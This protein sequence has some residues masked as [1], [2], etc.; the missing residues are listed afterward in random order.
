MIMRKIYVV[1]YLLLVVFGAKAQNPFLLTGPTDGI[2]QYGYLEKDAT[3]FMAINSNSFGNIF[4]MFGRTFLNGNN[5]LT[6]GTA[7]N[8]CAGAGVIQT[9]NNYNFGA[10]AIAG[11]I[12]Y[13]SV[14]A[15][16]CGGSNSYGGNPNTTGFNERQHYIFDVTDRPSDLATNVV[17]LNSATLQSTA[18][19]VMSLKIDFDA[20]STRTLE[21]LFIQN[22][23]TMLE[24]TD[25]ANDG[26]RVYYEAAT[27]TEVFNGT[28][29]FGTLFGDYNLNPTNNNIYGNDAINIPI[30]AGGL[31]IYVVLN[32]F[33]SCSNTAKTVQ[34]ST[35]NDG[36]SFSPAMDVSYRLARVN[37]Q[38]AAP[39]TINVSPVVNASPFSGNYYIPS[40]CYPTLASFITALNAGTVGGSITVNVAAGYTETATAGGFNITQTGTVA[41]PIV[42][43]K[44][45]AGANPTFTASGAHTAGSIVDAVF[46]IVGADYITI[47]GFTI[48]ENA[49]NVTSTP[50]GSNNMTEFGVGLFYTTVTDGPQNNTIRNCTISLNSTYTNTFGI[51]SNTQ[52]SSTSGTVSANITNAAT[53][54]SNNNRVYGCAISNVNLGIVFVGTPALQNTGIDIGG[55]SAATGNTLTNIGNSATATTYLGT[56]GGSCAGI[57]VSLSDGSNISYNS[58]TTAAIAVN[59]YG[60]YLRSTGTASAATH[61]SNILNNTITVS[62]SS[63]NATYSLAGILNDLG[64]ANHTLNMNNN[65]IQNSSTSSATF[66][67]A[68]AAIWSNASANTINITGN[69]IS[70]NTITGAALGTTAATRSGLIKVQNAPTVSVNVSNNTCLN[71]AFNN[72]GTGDIVA[73]DVSGSYVG[74]CTINNNSVNVLSTTGTGSI[75]GYFNGASPTGALTCD[76]NTFS[77]VTVSG[78]GSTSAIRFFSSST[79]AG[80]SLIIRNNT[81]YKLNLNSAVASLGV[82]AINTSISNAVTINNNSIRNVVSG[83][84][85]YGIRTSGGS[86]THSVYNNTVD[87]L[88]SPGGSGINHFG[89]DISPSSTGISN[90]YNNKVYN[91]SSMTSASA[92]IYGI[93][94]GDG[95]TTNIYN[96]MVADLKL[97]AT[98]ISASSALRG[99]TVRAVGTTANIYNN[100]VY[101]EGTSSGTD[102]SSAAFS[103]NGTT[104]NVDIRNN[105]FVNNCTPK[106]TGFAAAIMRLATGTNG[107]VPTNYASTSNNNCLFAPSVANGVVYV[108]GQYTGGGP[109][110]IYQ[111]NC[112]DINAFKAFVSTRESA[113]F[114]EIPPFASIAAGSSDL[115]IVPA[116]TSGCINGGQTIALTAADIDGA[117][118]PI[119]AAYEIGADEVAGTTADKTP[120]TIT[121]T[122]LGDVGCTT[123]APSLSATITDANTL[124][125]GTTAPRLY[126]KKLSDATNTIATAN[127]NSVGGW[128]YV[129]TASGASPYSFTFDYSLLPG[130]LISGDVIQYFVAAQDVSGN[131]ATTNATVKACATTVAFTS[132]QTVSSPPTI[133]Q[134]TYRGSIS[135]AVTIGTGLGQTYPTLSGVGGLFEAINNGYVSGDITATVTSNT[136]ETGAVA[137]NEWAEYNTGTCALTGTAVYRLT[138]QSD[139][140][141]RNLVGTDLVYNATTLQAMIN[142]NGADRVTFTGGT[143]TQR[144]LV[145][146]STHAT[147]T[148][149]IPVFQMGNVNG[150][151]GVIIK[152][153]DIQSNSKSATASSGAII[154][155][156]GTGTNSNNLFDNNDLH[157]AVAGTNGNPRFGIYANNNANTVLQITNNNIYNIGESGIQLGVGTTPTMGNGQIVTGNS[158]YNTAPAGST[159]GTTFNA[160][161]IRGAASSGHTISNNFVGGN[162]SAGGVTGSPYTNATHTTFRGIYLPYHASASTTTISGNRVTNIN[163]GSSTVVGFYGI[164]VTGLVDCNNNTIGHASDPA[165]GITIGAAGA[166]SA[167]NNYGIIMGGGTAVSGISANNNIVNYLTHNGIATGVSRLFGIYNFYTGAA[168]VTINMNNN[169]V[170][171][172]NSSMRGS[173]NLYATGSANSL[174]SVIGIL[175]GT[176]AS[177]NVNINGNTIF[178]LNAT[179]TL[180]GTTNP[181]I[182]GIAIDGGTTNSISRNRIYGLTNQSAGSAANAGSIVG[183]RLQPNTSTVDNNMISLSNAS[184]TNAAR[185]IGV[186]DNANTLNMYFNSIVIG[187]SQTAG[188]TG[189]VASAAYGSLITGGT[190]TVRNNIFYNTRTG[191][192]SGTT[193]HHFAI[194]VNAATT[195]LSSNYN[196]LRAAVSVNTC[197][198][199]TTSHTFASWRALTTNPTSPDA[200]SVNEIPYFTDAANGDLHLTVDNCELD[201][202]AI[203]VV[204]F[205]TDYDAQARNATTPDIGADEF[206]STPPTLVITNP[207]AVCAPGTVDLTAAAVTAGSTTG[208]TLTYWTDLAATANLATPNAV[209]VAGTYYIRLDKGSCKS[210]V[211]P[212][213]VTINPTGTVVWNGTTSTNWNTAANWSCGGIPTLNDNVII[214]SGAPNYPVIASGQFGTCADIEVQTGATVTATGTGQITLYGNITNTGGVFDVTDGTLNYAVVPVGL[215]PVQILSGATIKDKTVKNLMIS[216][217]L[218]IGATANNGD[219]VKVTGFV[220]FSGSSR[221]LFANG[222]LTLVSNA[223]GTAS[224]KDATNNGTVSGNIVDGEVNVERYIETNRKWRFLAMNTYGASQTIQNSWMENQT[225]GAIGVNGRGTWITDP[226]GTAQGFDAASITASMKYWNGSGYTNVTNPT[227]FNIKDLPAYMVFVRGDRNAQASNGTLNTTVLRTKGLIY[228]NT[229]PVATIPVFPTILPVPNVYPS[230]VDL[231]K[232]QYS[233]LG[234]IT[235]YV[236]DPKLTGSQGFGGFQTLSSPDGIADFTIIPGGG[237]YGA[238]GSVVNVIE[239]GQGLFMQGVGNPRTVTF[240]ETAKNPKE[241]DVFFTQGLEQTLDAQLSIVENNNSTLVDGVRSTFD[242]KNNNGFDFNDA[243][244]MLNNNENVSIKVAD[245]LLAVERRNIIVSDDT[246]QLNLAN[247]RLKNYQW[248]FNLS[249]LDEPGREAFLLD[250]FNNSSTVLNLNGNNTYNFSIVN[251]PASYANNRFAIVFKQNAV[252]LPIVKAT[253]ARLINGKVAINFNTEKESYV[254]NYVVEKSTD[255]LNFTSIVGNEDPSN[256][257]GGNASYTATDGNAASKEVLYYRVFAKRYAGGNL[258]SNVA[259]VNADIVDSYVKIYPNPVTNK[260]AQLEIANK[261]A[262][263][264]TVQIVDAKGRIV[265]NVGLSLLNNLERKKLILNN[266]ITAGVYSLRLVAED[267]T[268]SVEKLVVQ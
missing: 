210:T 192:T 205:T 183:I 154:Y 53:G 253:A 175:S 28:E 69:T 264:Y 238:A 77:N 113:S 268:N 101:L 147:N 221:Y 219:T 237:S 23:G 187:G 199:N 162:A 248:K 126:Y 181:G 7:I 255:G 71:N 42:F 176:A 254:D 92:Y 122:A 74:T 236:W 58:I 115:H 190:R 50:T 180:T 41:N 144:N 146:R 257:N 152:N 65:I 117:A 128:K 251:T 120:P 76:G 244:K 157:D 56:P 153:C 1:C 172:L 233:E 208:G 25:I 212:V 91:M 250:R 170:S 94:A 43:Q 78:G 104:T 211:L 106:G 240:V 202:K 217:V 138:V 107:T 245:K 67:G 194:A 99:I 18:N 46:K 243:Q 165:M 60:I 30:P 143:G 103:F 242:K 6:Y 114:S 168:G 40:I 220:S 235:A 186:W 52:H 198:S 201:G 247:V 169:T 37:Q 148:N 131:V 95:T 204:G 80:Q 31:R 215:A 75:Y 177:S 8:S 241:R 125:S 110:N 66:A 72:T 182:A 161:E 151:T 68:F 9:T 17:Q 256:N 24:G 116:S 38:P 259:K 188:G 223:S 89:I 209:G 59:A 119:G 258:Y 171:N 118:R 142:L 73:F 34:V 174:S 197:L 83:S 216:S 246:I 27:G 14:H 228:Q 206:T 97:P 149:G 109:T 33:N 105:I 93:S 26:F 127:N 158:V 140:N 252:A 226:A 139:G 225:P 79:G 39:A 96:N 234:S 5:I 195:T 124:G 184:Y 262:G 159:Y 21:R 4:Q 111:A 22:T 229:V 32:K 218:D 11:Q 51:Y 123:P 35:I 150:S 164:D 102:F 90:I 133:N 134:F 63:N 70:N 16:Y 203:P 227:V 191:G 12:A 141:V 189:A 13:T 15:D 193:V 167:A 173:G 166:T 224:I 48:Q 265:Q 130:G 214:P 137:L 81:I 222:N 196:S 3:T 112:F 185:V 44:F 132:T 100:S 230:A 86:G 267:G 19:V 82:T 57:L 29:S 179:T 61:T 20:V 260:V 85:I 155:I 98:S 261:P 213:V 55:T 45:G 88:Y 200:N 160:I 10:N 232:L 2:G 207:A 178:N 47:D 239:S 62:C 145:F 163:L 49:A 36:M 249:N 54:G 156:T 108:E 129:V 266:A 263:N 135:G 231:R 84:T 64:G 121:Y 136:V 87:S